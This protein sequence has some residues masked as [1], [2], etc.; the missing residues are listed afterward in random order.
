MKRDI[1]F[2]NATLFAAMFSIYLKRSKEVKQVIESMVPIIID[3][4][5]DAETQI[6]AVDTLVEALS[7]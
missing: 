1:V 7:D 6:A 5:T 4:N 2:H 3:P